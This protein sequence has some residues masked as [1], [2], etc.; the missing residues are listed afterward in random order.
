MPRV[1][2]HTYTLPYSPVP[3]EVRQ[4]MKE[5]NSQLV[6]ERPIYGR[7]Y[8]RGVVYEWERDLSPAELELIIATVCQYQLPIEIS[9]VNFGFNTFLVEVHDH[10]YTTGKESQLEV[11]LQFGNEQIPLALKSANASSEEKLEQAY[12]HLLRLLQPDAEYEAVRRFYGFDPLPPNA[13]EWR[14]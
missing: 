2:S 7:V 13:N 3:D 6:T 12:Q 10:H 5:L 4:Q 1:R 9:S 11:L 8:G 14:Y